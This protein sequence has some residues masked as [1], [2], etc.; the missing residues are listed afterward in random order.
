MMSD[1]DV[2]KYDGQDD[3]EEEKLTEDSKDFNDWVE[4]DDAT[5][6]TGLLD[7]KIFNSVSSLVE[8]EKSQW[9]FDLDVLV[10]QL[11]DDVTSF[12]KMIN[13]I[14]T[15]ISSHSEVSDSVVD[16]L[17]EKLFLKEYLSE[18]LYMTPA[19]PNDPLLYSFEDYF[20]CFGEDDDKEQPAQ[21][22]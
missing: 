19:L 2:N 21:E 17:K 13:F 7:N 22:R 14:R 3:E 9:N 16:Q 1:F 15:F 8:Y 4:D 20:G 10:P 12:I 5:V 11:C 18:E 6:I